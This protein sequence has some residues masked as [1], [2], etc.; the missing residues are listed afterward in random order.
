MGTLAREASD[1]S[2][3]FR[4]WLSTDGMDPA[5]EL[6]QLLERLGQLVAGRL[7]LLGQRRVGGDAALDHAELERH[8]D[9]PLLCPVVEVALEPPPLRVAGGDE[10]L[11]R[12]AQLGQ[13]RPG[14]PP[15]AAR[16]RA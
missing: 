16:R 2:A 13:L 6:A 12:G 4:P 7:E 11:A 14:T 15:G 8:G 5:R 1:S 3:A 9:E 10:T